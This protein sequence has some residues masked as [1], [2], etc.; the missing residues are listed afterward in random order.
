MDGS[1]LADRLVWLVALWLSLSVHEW[2]HAWSAWWLGDDTASRL[3]RRT[4]DPLAHLDPVGTV[5]LPLLGVPFGWAKPVPINPTRFHRGVALRAGVALTAAAGPVANLALT[6]L[7]VAALAALA[8]AAP[9]WAAPG[10]APRALLETIAALNFSLAVVNAVPVPPL[11]GSRV[12]EAWL[13]ARLEPAWRAFLRGG[14]WVL[15]A[16]LVAIVW[17]GAPILFWPVDRM[18]ALLAA[19]VP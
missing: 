2:A 10:A 3:G 1:G 8:A 17:L 13:P 18:R 12:L 7:A 6:L 4:L 19:I 16:A 11:D 15:A 14:D 9:A 5:L